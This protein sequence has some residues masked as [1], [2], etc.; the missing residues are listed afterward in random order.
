MLFQADT[1]SGRTSV[2]NKCQIIVTWQ[3]W[4]PI[5][6]FIET[7]QS[8]W[9]RHCNCCDIHIQFEVMNVAMWFLLQPGIEA[10]CTSLPVSTLNPSCLHTTLASLLS[11]PLSHTVP[12]NP[13]MQISTLPALSTGPPARRSVPLV[14]DWIAMETNIHIYVVYQ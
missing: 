2:P 1:S 4:N 13:L 12:H 6:S 3:Q 14:Q 9:S 5:A 11:H 7:S 8:Q 10:R